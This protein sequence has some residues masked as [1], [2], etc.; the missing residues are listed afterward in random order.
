MGTGYEYRL[1]SKHGILNVNSKSPIYRPG[2]EVKV[3]KEETYKNA[4]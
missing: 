4:M 2:E 3:M 1:E